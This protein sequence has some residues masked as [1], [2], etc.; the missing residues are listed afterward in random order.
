MILEEHLMQE[1]LL[2]ACSYKRRVKAICRVVDEEEKQAERPLL[3]DD[4]AQPPQADLS[5]LSP[6][7]SRSASLEMTEGRLSHPQDLSEIAEGFSRGN[8]GSVSSS[9]NLC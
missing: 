3:A 5:H 4:L 9:S 7:I 2:A 1:A 6:G 8:S